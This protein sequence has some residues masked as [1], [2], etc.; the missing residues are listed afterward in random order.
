MA[1]KRAPEEEDIEN[2]RRFLVLLMYSINTLSLYTHLLIQPFFTHSQLVKN[3]DLV[4]QFS[5]LD[6]L[7]RLRIGFVV[8]EDLSVKSL[9]IRAAGFEVGRVVRVDLLVVLFS[10]DEVRHGCGRR[11]ILG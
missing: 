10:M 6:D 3:A 9:L 2:G 7:G 4:P 11:A 8:R 5:R 1:G